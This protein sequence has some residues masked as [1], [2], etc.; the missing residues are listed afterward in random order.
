[1]DLI[2]TDGYGDSLQSLLSLRL[3]HQLIT[4]NSGDMIWM[5]GTLLMHLIPLDFG[6]PRLFKVKKL[7]WLKTEKSFTTKS[8][9]ECTILM[10]IRKTMKSASSLDGL[11]DSTNGYPHLAPEFRNSNLSCNHSKTKTRILLSKQ[12]MTK[13]MHFFTHPT[14]TMS[15][16]W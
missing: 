13:W 6:M 16:K 14:K 10:E 1:M 12:S 9:S 5:L 8:V 3:I 11:K 2:Q 4:M 7:K 15:A